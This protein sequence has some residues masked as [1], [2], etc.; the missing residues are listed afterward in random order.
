MFIYGFFLGRSLDFLKV[1]ISLHMGFA[2]HCTVIRKQEA[3]K[4]KD[5]Y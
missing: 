5:A 2:K 1:I 4:K 3:S